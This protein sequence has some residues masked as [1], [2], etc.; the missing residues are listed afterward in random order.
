MPEIR[1]PLTS[2]P[3]LPLSRRAK[4]EGGE[5]VNY[6]AKVSEDRYYRAFA[7]KA[8][9]L[10]GTPVPVD[11]EYA[12]FI[13]PETPWLRDVPSQILRNG[14]VRWKQAMGRFFS[15][16]SGRPVFQR[17]DG[18]Q[19][20]MVGKIRTKKTEDLST[21]P[22]AIRKH[23]TPEQKAQVVLELLKEADSTGRFCR[24]AGDCLWCF[25][26]TSPGGQESSFS[27]LILTIVRRNAP[28][29]G[30][31]IRTTGLPRPGLSASAADLPTMPITTPAVSLPKGGSGVFWKG[32]SRRRRFGGAESENSKH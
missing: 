12:R 15:G 4:R 17:K 27:K 7:K 24:P 5:D 18:R 30:T 2:S 3:S 16:L 20:I 23:H 6:N 1:L 28:G 31:F 32:K 22:T 26:P 9:S 11:C 14:A 13:G 29:A 21:M 8:V 25:C 19:S 10:S